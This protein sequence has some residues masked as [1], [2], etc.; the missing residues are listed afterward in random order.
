MSHYG[1]PLFERLT[2]HADVPFADR[3][4]CYMIGIIDLINN[5][6]S[7]KGCLFVKSCCEAGSSVIP[8]DV[9]LSL[10]N[11]IKANENILTKAVTVEQKRGLLTQAAKPKDIAEYLLSVLYGLTVLAKQGKSRNEMIRIVDIAINALPI[12]QS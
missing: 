6:E 11:M 7:P 4:R 3:V 5:K 2:E 12:S 8:E 9:A 1:A 10:Q